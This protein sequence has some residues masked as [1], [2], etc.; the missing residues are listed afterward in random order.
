MKFNPFATDDWLAT[1]PKVMAFL[2]VLLF[3]LLCFFE[4]IS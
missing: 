3:I 2:S 1:H 4:E